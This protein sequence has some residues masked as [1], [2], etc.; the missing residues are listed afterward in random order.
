MHQRLL[1]GEEFQ[2]QR[3]KTTR[4]RLLGGDLPVEDGKLIKEHM[5]MWWYVT[6][7]VILMEIEALPYVFDSKSKYLGR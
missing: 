5:A 4:N 6:M 2:S 7:G 3:P 1:S